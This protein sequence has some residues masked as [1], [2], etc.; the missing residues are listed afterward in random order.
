MC[1]AVTNTAITSNITIHTLVAMSNS[2]HEGSIRQR[3]NLSYSC[4]NH[5]D[6]NKNN[7]DLVDNYTSSSNYS[8]LCNNLRDS[9]IAA[10]TTTTTM[11][12]MAM[13]TE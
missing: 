7:N 9:G 12:A 11:M 10:T 3:N 6:D 2:D 5:D 4:G 13:S 8:E 1:T